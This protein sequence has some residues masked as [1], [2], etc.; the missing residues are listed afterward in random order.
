MALQGTLDAFG[1]TDV[2]RLLATTG[3]TGRLDVDARRRRGTVWLSDGAIAAALSDRAGG[4]A[5][6]EALAE[7]LRY[8]SGEFAF[9]VGERPHH[10]TRPQDVEEMLA[11]ASHLVR[12]WD[13]L[14]AVVPTLDHRVSLVEELPDR[15]E[16]VIDSERWTTLTAIGPGCTAGELAT[17]LE[18]T[19]LS[20]LRA[21]HDLVELGVARV[22]TP[23]ATSRLAR[24]PAAARVARAGS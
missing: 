18:L 17:S 22:D 20:L 7:L 8:E 4:A 10:E 23:V 12:E 6:A 14:Q 11:S 15:D 3:K 24:R 21:V 1:L 19:E 2:L 16:V 13:D 9:H 5:P